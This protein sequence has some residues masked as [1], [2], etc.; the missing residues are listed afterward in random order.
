VNEDLKQFLET[1]QKILQ[2]AEKL[3]E[4]RVFE[5]FPARFPAKFKDTRDDYGTNVSLR[6]ASAQGIKLITKERLFLHDSVSLEVKL[7]DNHDVITLRG[8]VVWVKRYEDVLWNVGVQFH[9]ID[10]VA[11]SRIYKYIAEA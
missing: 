10:L 8:R 11:I 2:E 9:K 5:R 1:S 3:Q 7:P 4:K 6:D